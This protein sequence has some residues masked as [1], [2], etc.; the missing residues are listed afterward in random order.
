MGMENRFYIHFLPLYILFCFKLAISFTGMVVSV[1]VGV[2]SLALNLATPKTFANQTKGLLGNFN[3]D[4]T[5][6]FRLPNDTLLPNNMTDREIHYTFGMAC[7]RNFLFV[8]KK[9][10]MEKSIANM[11]TSS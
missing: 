1:S 4:P 7:K 6:D 2:R 11:S 5:D 10:M 8:N 9:D 3:G